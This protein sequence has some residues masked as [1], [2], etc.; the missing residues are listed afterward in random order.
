MQY[1]QQIRRHT[2]LSASAIGPINS[3]D[4]WIPP[5]ASTVD[6]Y[7]AI[8]GF[9]AADQVDAVL[10]ALPK[11]MDEAK[12]LPTAPDSDQ[13][14]RTIQQLNMQKD[15]TGVRKAFK[16]VSNSLI[17]LIRKHG[18]D[19]LGT[20]FVVHCPMADGG[21]GADWLTGT[22]DVMNPYFGA[23]MLGCGEVTDTLSSK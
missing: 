7:L 19:Q 9:L 12:N 4:K 17:T 20:L 13:L 8:A 15:I 21:K 18:L 14:L 16:A 3:E 11:L 2:G 23:V 1:F 10:K 22:N 5:L 6:Q